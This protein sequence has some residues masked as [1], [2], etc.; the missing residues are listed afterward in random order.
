MTDKFSKMKAGSLGDPYIYLGAKV[1][2]MKINNCVTAWTISQIKYVNETVNN[3]TREHARI[4]AWQQS[5]QQ[6]SNRLFPLF[7]HNK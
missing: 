1:K 7:G 5:P 4:Q 6:I 3:G 2:P